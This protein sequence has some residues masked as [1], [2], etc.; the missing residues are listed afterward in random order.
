MVVIPE[1]FLRKRNKAHLTQKSQLKKF[2]SF[3]DITYRIRALKVLVVMMLWLWAKVNTI[4]VV[5][6]TNIKTV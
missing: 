6:K 4:L 2:R 5:L 1:F 3:Q